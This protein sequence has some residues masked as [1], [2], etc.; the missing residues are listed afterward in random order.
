MVL[1]VILSTVVFLVLHSTEL[2]GQ[3]YGNKVLLNLG[4][5][6]IAAP[7][8]A[9]LYMGMN[10]ARI[11]YAILCSII[12]LAGAVGFIVIGAPWATRVNAIFL[13]VMMT[14]M[15]F[16]ASVLFFSSSLKAYMKHK[17]ELGHSVAIQ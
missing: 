12:V 4:R 14:C 1:A 6:L 16:N 10:W 3:E 9:F 15:I 11:T 17:K 7:F 13:A 5:V 2:P 8:L